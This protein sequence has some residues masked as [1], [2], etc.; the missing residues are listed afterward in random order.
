MITHGRGGAGPEVWGGGRGRES[1]GIASAASSQGR[2][3]GDDAHRGRGRRDSSGGGYFFFPPS[4]F[5]NIVPPFFVFLRQFVLLR[6]LCGGVIGFGKGSTGKRGPR[7]GCGMLKQATVMGQS[8]G[9]AFR[10]GLFTSPFRS[11]RHRR[12]WERQGERGRGKGKR[13]PHGGCGAGVEVFP[14]GSGVPTHLLLKGWG[15][16]HTGEKRGRR[17]RGR[18]RRGHHDDTTLSFTPR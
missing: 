14:L 18:G 12:G 15:E 13:K 7:M 2:R 10:D 4:P 16:R 11:H 9:L 17:L 8:I 3:S 1:I 5:G 6:V